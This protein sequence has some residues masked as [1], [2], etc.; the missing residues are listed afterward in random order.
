[1]VLTHPPVRTS[2]RRMDLSLDPDRT[3]LWVSE[4]Q[5]LQTCPPCPC[6]SNR[7]TGVLTETSHTLMGPS[8]PN[9]S[10]S[11]RQHMELFPADVK[12]AVHCIVSRFQI[13]A[14][15]GADKEYVAAQLPQSGIAAKRRAEVCPSRTPAFLLFSKS[16]TTVDLSSCGNNIKRSDMAMYG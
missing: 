12:E 6:R 11:L 5:M 10:R 15:P 14:E 1:M 13:L 7:A 2:Q 4:P 3:T 16:H 8:D 9:S